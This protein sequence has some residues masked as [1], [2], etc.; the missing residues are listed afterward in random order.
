MLE[1]HLAGPDHADGVRDAL[2]RDV[3][4]TAVHGL[5]QAGELARRVDV[6]G[7]RDADGTRARGA[8][9][10]QDVAEQI[11]AD[12]DVEDLRP[13][14][15]VRR[16]D[17]DVVL[18]DAHVRVALLHVL[19]PRVPV[20]H[21]DADAV[22]LG[23]AGQ[24]LLG[25]RLRE[26]ERVLEHAVD[27]RAR[28]DRLLHD[29]L[30]VRALEDLAADAAVL[31]LGVL[32]HDPEVDVARLPARQGAFHARHQPR[33]PQV[34]VLVELAPELQQAA[35]EADVVGHLV[36][37]AH[38]AEVQRVELRQ[39]GVPV[40]R[41]HVAVRGVVGAAGEIELFELEC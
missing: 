8:Q 25:P 19:D 16:Q 3:G 17:V 24:M 4:R 9:V 26:V 39:R 34:D 29:G 31:A 12:D 36:R 41:E 38:G 30:A 20:R 18:V 2:A 28:H 10:G 35:P 21:R 27:A 14:H 5:K 32:A 33:R 1:H 11:A 23:R 7:R 40:C 13:L 37:H 6:A 22:T 15:K